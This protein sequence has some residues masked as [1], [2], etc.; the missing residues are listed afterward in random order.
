MLTV[1]LPHVTVEDVQRNADLCWERS[2]DLELD[3]A[4]RRMWLDAARAAE[5]ALRDAGGSDVKIRVLLLWQVW[6]KFLRLLRDAFRA[7]F[8]LEPVLCRFFEVDRRRGTCAGC[9]HDPTSS[10]SS[11]SERTSKHSMT[12]PRQCTR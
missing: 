8:E 12:T 6:P 11:L 5:K 4:T 9:D 10:T 3:P 2:R 1:T 7:R